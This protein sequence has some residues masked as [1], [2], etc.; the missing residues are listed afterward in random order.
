MN[1]LA[2][3]ER[4]PFL[5]W[6]PFALGCAGSFFLSACVDSSVSDAESSD[7]IVVTDVHVTVRPDEIRQVVP[8]YAYGMHTSV[9]DNAL[10]DPALPEQL[11]EAGI[12][13][14]RYPGGSYSDLYHWSNHTMTP[15]Y[16]G[17]RGY[18]AERS[19]FGSYV[20]VVD[21]ADVAVMITA[22]YGS[23][24]EGSGGGEPN[25]AAAWVAYANGSPDDE[26]V[27]GVDSK[28]HDWQSVGTWASLRA[29]NPLPEDDGRNFLR[30]SHPEPLGI[31][32]WEIGNEIFGN[33]FYDPPGWEFDLHAPYEDSSDDYADRQGDPDLS[34]GRYGTEVLR[35][36]DAMKAVDPDIKVGAVL[37]TPPYDYSW[38]PDWNDDVLGECGEQID[39]AILHWYPRESSFLRG[40]ADLIPAMFTEL[41]RSLSEHAP[42]GADDIEVVVTEV[43]NP[44]DSGQHT[45]EVGGIFAADAYLGF[46]EQGV[47][48]I[49]WLELHNRTFLSERDD[50]RGPA[51]WGISLANRVAAAG[52]ALVESSSSRN[53]VVVVHAGK[54]QDGA[55]TVM[56]VNTAT[57]TRG[58]VTIEIDSDALAQTAEMYRYTPRAEGAAGDR[59]D[60]PTP[61]DRED[62]EW[63]VTTEPES[64]T[65]L[66]IPAD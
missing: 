10:H 57:R 42:E 3:L 43:G 15:Q 62:G 47:T 11:D 46:I 13:M 20:S 39:F 9:Y 2:R 58:Q 22:N 48:N 34:G 1:R 65:V 36:I 21:R 28:G 63:A 49:D 61:L 54:R 27:I 59:I 56:L 19:D 53:Y 32:Y 12:T 40:P 18:L 24:L 60:G 64:V 4:T 16:N 38:A 25:E 55:V 44:V 29:A 50:S 5:V 30:I 23:N 6:T 66:E 33:G 52:D 8:P 31:V 17:D 35:Y 41:G 51:F 14:L 37:V 26:T 7:E 45:R